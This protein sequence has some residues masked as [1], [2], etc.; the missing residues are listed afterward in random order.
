MV[1]WSASGTRTPFCQQERRF[2]V[3]LKR[4]ATWLGS[5]PESNYMG[6]AMEKHSLPATHT[7][8]YTDTNAQTQTHIHK[9]T[10]T[11]CNTDTNARTH[12]HTLKHILIQTQTH[13]HRHRH[14]H[15]NTL[16]YRETDRTRQA[17][18]GQVSITESVTTQFCPPHNCHEL[19]VLSATPYQPCLPWPASHTART[20]HVQAQTPITS[21]L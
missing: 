18:A 5:D 12:T 21:V 10:H 11:Y 17:Y 6:Q 4:H 2:W 16:R 3:S 7:Y 14:R 9:C 19:S 15:T 1:V 8:W 20:Y 13:R